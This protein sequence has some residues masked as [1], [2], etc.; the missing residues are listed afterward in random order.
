MKDTKFVNEPL[1]AYIVPS[2]DSHQSE[3]LADCD[4][5]RQFISGFTGST[6]TAIITNSKA[7]LWTDGR[8]FL[9]AE[10][11]L[12]AD[13]IL[14]KDGEPNVPT[15]GEWLNVELPKGSKV[16]IDPFLVPED[17]WG[18]LSKKLESGGNLLVPSRQN[19]V[20]LAWVDRPPRPTNPI[21]NLSLKLTGIS[22]HEKVRGIHAEMKKKDVKVLVVTA[23]DEIAWLLNLRGSDIEYNPVFFAYVVL[24]ME[25]LYFFVDG[26]KLSQS[27]K[28]HLKETVENF[29]FKVKICAYDE[30]ESVLKALAVAEGNK[31]WISSTSSHALVSLIDKTKLVTDESPVKET[32]AVKN[33]TEVENMKEAHIKDAV[34]LCE[35]FSW[36]EEKVSNNEDV[37]EVS[38][39][40]KLQ[41][42]RKEQADYVSDSFETISAYAA[43]GAVIHY[44]PSDETDKRIGDSDLY[45]CDSGAQYSDGTTD[46]TRTM[47]F[48][49][50]TAYEKECFTRV[51]KGHISLCNVIFPTG[52]KGHLLDAFAR[53]SLWEV[54][55]D[56][57]HGTGHGVGAFLNVHEGPIGISMRCRKE[58]S[59]IEE[60]MILT[61]E[62]GYY[63]NGKF[64]I[65]I[66]NVV[67]VTKAKTQYSF[68]NKSS[69]R[70]EPI[71]LVPIQSKMIL[72]EMLTAAE[73]SWLNSYHSTCR[74]VV[75][76]FLES[77]NRKKALE[78]LI[79]ETE[80]II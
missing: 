64:G 13:W 35:Y 24:T 72:T 77:Q 56:Y 5:R 32:K 60:N 57:L 37:T 69:L 50:P 6:G 53:T 80:P 22:W 44:R 34:A 12:E 54:G 49:N 43:N 9:Q 15:F 29:V 62:P 70:F 66:E 4:K 78:W 75:G 28:D 30:V 40:K 59:G 18:S 33:S 31:F 14:M 38:G 55:L 79:K 1:S 21:F 48:G 67:L 52:T 47:H 23:L 76:K 25:T 51:L 65:R 68:N 11:E 73:I 74:N 3:Y 42:F 16:G 7:A 39:A 2:C 71:T 26:A 10:K 63:E 20:D 46:V 61:D 41:E 17:T 27:V 36:L 45:L 8:Y 58:D 19:L